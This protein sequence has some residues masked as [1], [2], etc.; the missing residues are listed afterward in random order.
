MLHVTQMLP[1]NTTERSN[2]DNF[3]CS[4][5]DTLGIESKVD[6]KLVTADWKLKHVETKYLCANHAEVLDTDDFRFL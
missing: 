6:A 5:C 3:I 2:R 4:E 1:L